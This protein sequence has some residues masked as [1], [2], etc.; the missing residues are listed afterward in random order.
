[1]IYTK[2][3]LV[4][5][6]AITATIGY[7]LAN[8]DLYVERI[9]LNNTYVSDGQTGIIQGTVPRINITIGNN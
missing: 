1:M 9:Q 2:R 8:S 4:I 5:I 7:G 6:F 3:L